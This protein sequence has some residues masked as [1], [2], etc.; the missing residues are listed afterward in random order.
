MSKPAWSWNDYQ[1]VKRLEQRR[2]AR[3]LE[4]R[5]DRAQRSGE[6]STADDARGCEGR[7]A[8]TAQ[9][10]P[11]PERVEAVPGDHGV[12]P[13]KTR[14]ACIVPVRPAAPPP[15]V[16]SVCVSIEGLG[17]RLAAR[18][19]VGGSIGANY[20]KR[21]SGVSVWCDQCE[22]LVKRDKVMRCRSRFCKA[23]AAAAEAARML[24]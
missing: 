7:V 5:S 6:G 12:V 10:Q 18:Q 24:P 4:R 2:A 17:E 16:R 22:R 9:A 1:R 19:A 8:E 11:V 23:K 13:P 21:K 15:P 20:D 14:Q 3:A